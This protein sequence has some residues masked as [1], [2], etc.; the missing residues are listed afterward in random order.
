M[1]VVIHAFLES[2]AIS[3]LTH[4]YESRGSDKKGTVLDYTIDKS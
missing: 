1:N 2:T 3:E 4:Y